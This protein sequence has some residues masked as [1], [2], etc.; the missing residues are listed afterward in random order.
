MTQASRAL[1]Q[2]YRALA[3]D[4]PTRPGPA[5]DQRQ[6]ERLAYLATRLPATFAAA[7]VALSECHQRLA[8]PVHRVLDLGA[9][10]GTV[11]WAAAAVFSELDDLTAV[12]G[13]PGWLPLARRLAAHSLS[14]ALSQA[15][16]LEA[17]LAA[18]LP[19][20]LAALAP[21]VIV[22]AYL[23]GELGARGAQR[24]VDQAWTL[25]AA[26]L[27]LVEPGT[28]RGFETLLHA[29][30]SLLAQGAHVLAPCPHACACPLNAPDWC[31]FA[32]RLERSSAH[33]QAKRATLGHEDEK[34]AYLVMAR[35]PS[36]PA[37]ARILRHPLQRGG[38]VILDLCTPDG[39]RRQTVGRR[40]GALYR[41]ARRAHWGDAWDPEAVA[42]ED[43][44]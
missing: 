32:A 40:A 36:Q 16:W 44:G 38:H 31:H 11:A 22:A 28:P 29:R 13:D 14:P 2:R 24:V 8:T 10:P 42:E 43:A 20:G 21:D 18:G 3:H 30:T 25:G 35:V 4:T 5:P 27:V 9:G 26:A 23:L 15:R 17:D 33:R 41:Q 1:S 39:A 37:S 12:E 7:R 34:F 19:A 6:A